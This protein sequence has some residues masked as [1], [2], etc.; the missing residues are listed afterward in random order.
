VKRKWLFAFVC[1]AFLSLSNQVWAVPPLPHTVFG[2]VKSNGADVP[3]GTV[4]SAW[5]GEVLYGSTMTQ[6]YEGGSVFVFRVPGDNPDTTE[7]EGGIPGEAIS[8][9]VGSDGADPVL[10]F[11]PGGGTRVN[12]TSDH[13]LS[14][15][16]VEQGGWC[17]GKAPCRSSMQ[18]AINLAASY[19]LINVSAE[20]YDEDVFLEGSKVLLLQGGWDLMFTEHLDSTTIYGSLTIGDGKIIIQSLV[21]Q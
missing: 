2:S 12:L 18:S 13:M 4:V 1:L 16:F 17:G 14:D 8:F 10:Y 19:T 3:D 9:R 20:I 5:I 21:I 15:V 7:K 11:V 6:T